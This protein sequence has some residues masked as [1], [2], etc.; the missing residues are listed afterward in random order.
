M[1]VIGHEY[2]SLLNTDINA[3]SGSSGVS[4]F[5]SVTGSK[6]LDTTDALYWKTSMISPVRFYEAAKE[7]LS[8]KRGPNF[9]IEVGPSGTLAGAVSQ[10]KKSL[11]SQ[12]TDISL[13][14]P[15]SRG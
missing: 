15:M 1:N 6:K 12:G 13:T 5:S 8:E 14:S 9:L 3:L 2:E 11:S 7:M 10:I 4:A